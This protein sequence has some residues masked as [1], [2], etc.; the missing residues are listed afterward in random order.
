MPYFPHTS[1]QGG[2]YYRWLKRMNAKVMLASLRQCSWY[3]ASQVTKEA[4]VSQ[5][6]GFCW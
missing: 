3:Q 6:L 1:D 4:I 5:A 2:D